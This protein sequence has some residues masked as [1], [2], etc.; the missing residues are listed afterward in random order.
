MLSQKEL[1]GK[2]EE[3][4]KEYFYYKHIIPK[5]YFEDLEKVRAILLG[6]NP[7][8]VGEFA[9]AEYVF[10]L[11][12]FNKNRGDNPIFGNIYDNLSAI[13]LDLWDIYAQNLCKNYFINLSVHD[14]KW[15]EIAKLWSLVIKEELDTLFD[16]DIPVL[17][18]APWILNPLVDDLKDPLYYYEKKKFIN[19]ENNKLG[20]TLIP[21]FRQSE[22]SLADPRWRGYKEAIINLY[23][24]TKERV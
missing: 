16:K 14:E 13:G 3:E 24:I 15:V 10:D 18:T 17:V 11:T 12:H 4:Y 23:T 6:S 7:V 5:A 19:P 21:F 22:Y 20:R 9:G 8:A 1:L 2:L